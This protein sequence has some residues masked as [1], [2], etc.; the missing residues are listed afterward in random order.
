VLIVFEGFTQGGS[1]ADVVLVDAYL[2]NLTAG[3]DWAVG[4]EALISDAEVEPPDW[5]V[6]GRG[7]LDAWKTINYIPKQEGADTRSVS[8]TV[9]YAYNDFVIALLAKE[10][11]YTADYEKYLNRS[12]NWRN[13]FKANQTSAINGVDTGYTGFLQPR[14][15]NGTW[16]SQ[17]TIRC[18]PLL[19]FTS[20]YLNPQGGE[21]YEGPLFMY[22]FFVPQDMSSLITTLGGKDAFISRLNFL[23]E[24]GL[25]Y[26]G[27]EQGF[28]M[29][30]L[31]HYAG[32]PGLSAARARSYIPSQFNDTI[33]GIP[34]ND[35]SGA[36]GSFEALTMMGIF[37]NAGQDVYFITPPFFKEV[38][39]KSGQTGQ[40]A[41][42]KNLNFDPE[43]KNVFV[44]KA[45]LNGK[46]YTRNWLQHS[47][48]MDGGTLEL[49]LGPQE[50]DWGTRA[51][52]VPP[53]LG[54]G[55]GGNGTYRW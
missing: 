40:T 15:P 53:S 36:M 23:H 38:S 50:S 34:G 29:V 51:E 6:E 47:F 45:T 42:I 11:G 12:A 28:L 46:P 37:P 31:Y 19:E 27:D 1:N 18:S 4:Y 48:F 55:G 25:L 41:T 35:D 2:K 54:P 3:I 20:C 30:Y 9:E 8:R 7:G 22:T 21:A 5:T 49:T 24:S 14:W 43:G 39:I 13:V 44:Q 33:G 32:R 10:L 16:A 52:D 26:M 17:D